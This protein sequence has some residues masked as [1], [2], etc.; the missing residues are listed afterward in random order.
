M[1]EIEIRELKVAVA[2]KVFIIDAR[3]TAQFADGFVMGAINIVLNQNFEA[4]AEYFT[5]GVEQFLLIANRE[6][7]EEVGALGEEFK[8]K[9]AGIHYGNFETW[10]QNDIPIDLIIN[11]DPYE[12]KLD[13][14][15]DD[16]AVV[17]DVR[18]Q[19]QYDEE[20]IV[21]A[22][23]MQLTD[24]NDPAKIGMLDEKHN[25]YLHCNGGTASVLI[26]SVLKRH[27]FHNI[28]N[29]EGGIRAVREDGNIPLNAD[30]KKSQN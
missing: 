27:G 20:H 8:K 25:L 18:A 15:H 2:N 28:R 19:I 24:F 26:S 3:P 7:L 21:G 4:R 30:N 1:Q 6:D 22:V 17:I 9:I 10:Q 14:T 16:K 11:V 12:L 29:I 23:N 5:K 13:I